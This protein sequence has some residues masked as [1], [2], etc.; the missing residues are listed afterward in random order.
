MS[1]LMGIF[2]R[3]LLSSNP[4]PEIYLPTGSDCLQEP[5]TVTA[6]DCWNP[7]CVKLDTEESTNELL[8][9]YHIL[10][11]FNMSS[12]SYTC[13]TPEC[14]KAA[15]NILSSL[16]VTTQPCDDFYQFVCGGWLDK[17]FLSE[18]KSDVS[19]I[20]KLRH[21]LNLRIK[22]LLERETIE[23][24]PDFITM[25]K[26]M[27][28]SCMCI[29]RIERDGS[30]PLKEILRDLGGWPVVEGS[31]WNETSFD[32]MDTVSLMSRMGYS[33][34]ILMRLSVGKDDRNNTALIIKLDQPSLGMPDRRFLMQGLNDPAVAAYFKL[35]V[36][37]AR[38]LGA[39]KR[40]SK[41][42]LKE[43]LKFEITLA[44]FSLPREER[45]N[46]TSMYNKYTVKKLIDDLPQIRWLKYFNGL[47]TDNI[48]ETETLIVVAPAF[49]ERFADFINKTNKRVIANY[50]M[51]TV[52]Q[53]SFSLLS[54]DWR[55]LPQ[56]Y[57]S[58]ISGKSKE[59]PRWEHCVYSIKKY[60]GLAVDAYYK[61]NY[62]DD[63]TEEFAEFMIGYILEY[64]PSMLEKTNWLSER[65][66]TAAVE[67]ATA[68]TY[69]IGLPDVF[70]N[71]SIVSD[72]YKNLQFGN[73]NYFMKILKVRRW[74]TYS[75]LSSLRKPF[76]KEAWMEHTR[77]TD[78]NAYY[79]I[80]RN[81]I[82]F[83][84]GLLLS[85]LFD[86]NRPYY[87]NFGALGS[88]AGHEMMHGFDDE[89]RQFN[90]VG[91]N[92][93]WWDRE[94]D[95]IFRTKAQCIIEQYGNYTAEN[96]LQLNGIT[97]QGENIADNGGLRLAYQSYKRATIELGSERMLPGLN[98]T[99]SQ[100]FW[101]SAAQVMCN[102]MTPEL[103]KLSILSDSHTLRKFRA[104]GPMSNLPEFAEDFQCNT[105]SQMN[106]ET[107]CRVW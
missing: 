80:Y 103:Q 24:E 4:K 21:E 49:V 100:L 54:N 7:I 11:L 99:T 77:E 52:V 27:Y 13:L 56:E 36:K 32:W 37:A 85:P 61:K 40:S 6:S 68:L 51:W 38:K 106:R 84:P 73:E 75:S 20:S 26:G 44:N 88:L 89:G 92:V 67:K 39:K 70:L 34:N 2:C 42:E 95:E 28:D 96:G 10:P 97:T 86:K 1:V 9:V 81:L 102:K 65:T 76:V 105:Y 18:D 60:F 53:Q 29:E 63:S 101:I 62:A 87:L 66:K 5:L 25:I 41:K 16:D 14:T 15:A 94:S 69:R 17:H 46:F 22:N 23:N 43:A 47:L 30:E 48:T 83:N 58:V 71:D 82:V 74:L 107:K 90:K 45:R 19:V 93:N 3:L 59:T 72:Q 78:A 98:Y 33:H 91:N 35:M 79:D 50:M 64:L 8:D 31:N 57:F 55:N 104:I 12:D